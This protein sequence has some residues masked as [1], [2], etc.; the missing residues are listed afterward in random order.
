MANEI[1]GEFDV[2]VGDKTYKCHLDVN[3]LCEAE[4]LL[5]ESAG[6]FAPKIGGGDMR[7]LR[8]V[9]W[10]ALREHH[11]DVDLHQAGVI[12]FEL[13]P[14]KASN[15]LVLGMARAFPV[16]K[17]ASKAGASEGGS[18]PRAKATATA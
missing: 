9:M 15:H 16:A 13:T 11:S 7:T 14:S 6:D 8:A 2:P 1:K 17:A 5:G 4:E 12:V 10:A 18:R 3:A